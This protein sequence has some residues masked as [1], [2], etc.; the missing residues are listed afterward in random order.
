MSGTALSPEE[1]ANRS[2][3]ALWADDVATR[4]LGI[5]R[6]EV[7]PGRARLAMTVLET[8]TNGHGMCH[9]GYIFL[10]ADTAFAYACNSHGSRA[11]AQHAQVSFLAPGR[12]GSRLTDEAVERH[13]G[14]R[15]GICDVTVRDDSGRTIAEFRGVSRVIPGSLV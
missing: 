15:S 1:T 7:G 8:M 11:V 10:L 9:G 13:R 14:D 5:E 2:A 3:D 12:L 6:L 4:S